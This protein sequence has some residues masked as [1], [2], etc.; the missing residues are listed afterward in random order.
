MQL[1]QPY[2]R[3]TPA[4]NAPCFLPAR[5]ELLP[6]RCHSRKKDSTVWVAALALEIM[7]RWPFFQPATLDKEPEEASV[8][9]EDD[10]VAAASSDQ[11]LW[12]SIG[13]QNA[14]TRSISLAGVGPWNN[15]IRTAR[16]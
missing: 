12:V 3:R 8:S 1:L 7:K 10:G 2:H 14:L 15:C 13:N 6:G 16:P 11:R 4:G 5:A 9:Q